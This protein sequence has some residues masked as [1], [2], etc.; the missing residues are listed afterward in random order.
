MPNN[1]STEK[2]MRQNEK[3]RRKNKSLKTRIK[4]KRK[5]IR[6]AIEDENEARAEEALDELYAL[7]D[8]AA[9]KGAIHKNKASR[10]KS[11]LTDRVNDL[12]TD[13]DD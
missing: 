5:E 10:I 1:P 9:G 4:N 2:R 8:R 11:R 7:C 6:Q 12:G 3:R 13:P